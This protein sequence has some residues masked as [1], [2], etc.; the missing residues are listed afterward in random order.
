[1]IA[2]MEWSME[3]VAVT[4]MFAAVAGFLWSLHRDMRGMSRDVGEL[5]ERVARDLG[6]LSD[7][8]ARDMRGLSERIARV[9]GLLDGMRPRAV[10][11]A[12]RP[13]ETR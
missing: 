12:D 6:E 8:V 3:F 13:Q 2:A 9:E 11:A 10:P 7:R 1:M 4:A 5:A